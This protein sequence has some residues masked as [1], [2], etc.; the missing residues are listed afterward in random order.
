MINLVLITSVI[1]TSSNCLS[2]TNTRSVYTPDER[3]EQTKKTIQSI[4]DKIP[5]YKIF[6]IECS[7]LTSEQDSYLKENS[8]YFLNLYKN[9]QIKNYVD[10]KSKSLGEGSMTICAIEYIN[11]NNI[12]YDNLIKISGR[13]WL[14][15]VFKYEYLNN[16]NIVI[17]YINGDINS[18]LTAIYKLPKKYTNLFCDFLKSNIVLM[19]NNIGY[20]NIFALFI[21]E[22][23]YDKELIKY[24]SSEFGLQGY[25][26][27]SD[28][29]VMLY[30]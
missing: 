12:E 20:E 24:I 18:V 23:S 11:I 6:T 13:Y 5:N 15:D 25:I 16:S 3:F 29:S 22:N 14:S 2:Y 1:K 19:K 9:S 7:E 30:T 4:K 17:K 26:S 21:K 27:V 10:G 8:D 28:H